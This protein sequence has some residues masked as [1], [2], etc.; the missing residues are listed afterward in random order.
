M[1]DVDAGLADAAEEYRETPAAI[2][3]MLDS[4]E[5]SV[6]EIE[7]AFDRG[8]LH[9]ADMFISS[10]YRFR[11]N[12]ET[13][14][15]EMQKVPPYLSGET[16][17][18]S[19]ADI[20]DIERVS[21]RVMESASEFG[22]A[23]EQLGNE[24]SK[25]G[26]SEFADSL[27]NVATHVQRLPASI[28]DSVLDNRLLFVLRA[29]YFP[30]EANSE[31]ADYLAEFDSI[32]QEARQNTLSGIAIIASSNPE[33][34]ADHT[35]VLVD[36]LPD[37]SPSETQYLLGILVLITEEETPHREA[38]IEHALDLIHSETDTIALYAAMVLGNLAT[39]EQQVR[40][41]SKRAGSLL[42]E[43][44]V[45]E[46]KV[47][48]TSALCGLAESHPDAV[49]ELVPDLAALL[50]TGKPSTTANAIEF[51]ELTD[52]VSYRS[53]IEEIRGSTNSEQ[54][55]QAARSA[56]E[57]FPQEQTAETP[58]TTT[59]ADTDASSSILAELEAEFR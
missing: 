34:V 33:L 4:I 37:S 47:N 36:R 52:A 20:D 25:L 7:S 15:R 49:Q 17:P 59:T 11:D 2:N 27:Y 44:N 29:E 12:A 53:K 18:E 51:L 6:Q 14:E 55:E 13:L 32:G 3:D 41:A 1:T 57:S 43:V 45:E 23:A 54:V 58:E 39:T 38:I 9:A 35:A 46:P 30:T 10:F 31:I 19:P 5:G 24:M 22:E 21:R 40:V 48:V 16:E 8:D 56:L 50:E 42:Q 28:E 26:H